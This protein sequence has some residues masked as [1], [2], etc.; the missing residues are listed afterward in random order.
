MGAARAAG[1][2]SSPAKAGDRVRRDVEANHCRCGLLDTPR[3]ALRD[4]LFDL[5]DTGRPIGISAGK[6]SDK[7]PPVDAD[8][9]KEFEKSCA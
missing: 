7:L 3:D 9:R 8:W 6:D 5:M 2:P 1:S 4:R